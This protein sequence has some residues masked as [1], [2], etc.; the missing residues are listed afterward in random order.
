MP[1]VS[2]IIPLYNVEQVVARCLDSVCAQAHGDLE[3]IVVDDAST[4][5]SPDV[6]CQYAERDGRV[7]VIRHERNRGLHLARMTGVRA[8][9]G[10]YA[11]LLDSD[12]ALCDETV[13]EKL[14][15]E[16]RRDPVDVLRFGLEA[17]PIDGT[18]QDEARQLSAWSNAPKGTLTGKE[19]ACLAF[20]AE[21]HNELPWHV[22]H[23]LFR[24]DMLREAFS[25]M[26]T[27]RLERAEDA[28]EYF[29]MTDVMGLER[30]AC[31][32]MGYRYYLGGGVMNARGLTLEGFL[33]Q[34]A[35]IRDCYEAAAS[36]AARSDDPDYAIL[37]ADL[38]HKLLETIGTMWHDRVSSGDKPT[39]ALELARLIGPDEAGT[40]LYRFVR[41]RA[42]H[43]LD[44]RSYPK[45]GDELLLLL[46]VARSVEVSEQEGSAE[47]E[48]YAAMRSIAEQH[49]RDLL[50][51]QGETGSLA[52][53][54]DDERR[55][56]AFLKEQLDDVV[57]SVSFRIGRA[58][59]AL[60]RHARD[61]LRRTRRA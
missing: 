53:E 16:V 47:Y 7:R 37:A 39:A 18:S 57:G 49:V 41:D 29:V 31:D 24:A 58:L 52:Q 32:I 9:T 38:R 60:P 11:L 50:V 55:R 5:G 36:Y 12:D 48:R 3:I 6:A 25:R 45:P 26:S 59:T 2:I 10:A 34:A 42:Y 23:R 22:T 20:A 30:D 28:Y 61:L 19:A 14:V 4:D 40:E 21:S 44:H 51:P 35:A 33:S 13:I 15:S 43:H 17:V 46:G 56:S 8:M 1:K 27:E 54:L